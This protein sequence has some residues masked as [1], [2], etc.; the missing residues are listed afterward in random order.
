LDPVVGGRS[1]AGWAAEIAAV[2]ILIAVAA[3]GLSTPPDVLARSGRRPI[4]VGLALSAVVSLTALS[5]I[6]ATGALAR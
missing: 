4:L 5:L 3:I 6:V 2:L 1:L